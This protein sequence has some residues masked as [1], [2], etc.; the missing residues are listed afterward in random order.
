M[1]LE[2]FVGRE[3]FGKFMEDHHISRAVEVGTLHG[4]FAIQLLK[5]WNG[6]LSCVDSFIG[7]YDD[8]DPVSHNDRNQD[9]LIA[10]NALRPYAA[11]CELLIMSSEQ[12][13]QRAWPDLG[14]VYVD[15]CHRIESVR[16]DLVLW[17]PHLKVGGVL[18]GHD[19][20]LYPDVQ[21]AVLEF[22]EVKKV[23]VY[24][25]AE[26]V[27]LAWSFYMEKPEG[28]TEDARQVPPELPFQ[29]PTAWQGGCHRISE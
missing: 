21:I 2:G 9:R 23:N 16:Q 17:W 11:R 14:L 4:E 26:K 27:R 1:L 8:R 7:G 3:N 5:G 25:V 18:A 24:V 19:F 29:P 6:N 20:M 15:G 10:E 13:A 12:A 22:A 28:S